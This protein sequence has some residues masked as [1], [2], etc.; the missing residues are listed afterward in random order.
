MPSRERTAEL[1]SVQARMVQSEKLASIGRLA[2]GVAHG[3][4]KMMVA[5]QAFDLG[6]HHSGSD[7]FTSAL[8]RNLYVPCV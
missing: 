6:S 3:I 8:N 5:E 2:A 1:V 4:N 7:Y